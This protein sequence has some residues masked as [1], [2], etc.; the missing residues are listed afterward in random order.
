MYKIPFFAGRT[1]A[2]STIEVTDCDGGNVNFLEHVQTHV[3][4]GASRRGDVVIWLVSP[5]GARSNLVARRPK[6]Y[7]RAGFNDW[8][9]LSVSPSDQT[10]LLYSYI[11]V[12]YCCV[13]RVSSK[14]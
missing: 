8:P 9:F 12:L 6:D 7:S 14:G 13:V 1:V 10:L 4:L 11:L 5:S 3:T 2:K